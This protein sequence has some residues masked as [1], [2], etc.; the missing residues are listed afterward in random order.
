MARSSS[1]PSLSAQVPQASPYARAAPV[2]GNSAAVLF[3][4]GQALDHGGAADDRHAHERRY[5]RPRRHRVH[6][7]RCRA[8]GRKFP[9]ACKRRDRGAAVRAARRRRQPGLPGEFP[10]APTLA[11]AAASA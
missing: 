2:N 6:S 4:F 10:C 9:T 11:S 8:A 3:A 1:F 5:T 7:A